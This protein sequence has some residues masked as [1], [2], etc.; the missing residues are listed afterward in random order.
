MLKIGILVALGQ[1]FDWLLFNFC[2]L[3]PFEPGPEAS[4]PVEV[5]PASSLSAVSI[6]TTAVEF[7]VMPSSKIS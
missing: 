2:S 5:A 7:S 3:W 6:S 1:H 4:L